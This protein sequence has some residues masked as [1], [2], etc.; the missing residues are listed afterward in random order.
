MVRSTLVC[1]G[2]QVY[3]LMA[4]YVCMYLWDIYPD[5]KECHLGLSRYDRGGYH[6]VHHSQE[7][8][9]DSKRQ[10]LVKWDILFR[11]HVRD[12]ITHLHALG[13]SSLE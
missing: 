12:V 3:A 13:S 10:R 9:L 8:G 6:R 4:L 7:L 5:P 11:R 1:G 2:E